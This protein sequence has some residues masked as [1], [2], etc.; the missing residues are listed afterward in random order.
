[1][2]TLTLEHVACIQLQAAEAAPEECCGV[3]LGVRAEGEAVVRQVRPAPN[4]FEGDRRTRYELDARAHLRAQREARA[5]GL[6][7]LGFY[8]SHPD[9]PAYP[10]QADLERAWPG[11]AYLIVTPGDAEPPARC[12]RLDREAWRFV[13]EPMRLLPS[14]DE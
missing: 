12:W 1:M 14:D 10:S 6:E 5:G 2:L 11:Y 7:V 13:E 9:G 8:H 4:V 3:L